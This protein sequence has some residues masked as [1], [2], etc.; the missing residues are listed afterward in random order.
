[1]KKIVLDYCVFSIILLTSVATSSVA[2]VKPGDTVTKDNTAQAE[3]LLT[4]ATRWMVEQGR[5]GAGTARRMV[6]Q[7][8]A[9]AT[10]ARR[11][12]A[13]T[14]PPSASRT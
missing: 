9:P 12:R 5:K 11:D 13:T 3:T 1:M 4:P 6:E 10:S 14:A 8:G 2:D 7:R